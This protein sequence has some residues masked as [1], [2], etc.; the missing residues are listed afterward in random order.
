MGMTSTNRTESLNQ[1]IHTV[2]RRGSHRDSESG[3]LSE[4]GGSFHERVEQLN[5]ID[6]QG[7][8]QFYRP[9][10][11]VCVLAGPA[12]SPPPDSTMTAGVVCLLVGLGPPSETFLGVSIKHN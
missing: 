4:S 5:L 12:P 8:N 9:F 6:E 2:G 11:A 10:G 1:P 3:R 7:P